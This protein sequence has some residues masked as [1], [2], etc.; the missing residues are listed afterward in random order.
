MADIQLQ[1]INRSIAVVTIEGTAPLIVHAWSQKARTMMLDA[2]QGRKTPKQVKDP[3]A[4]FEATMYRFPDGGHGFPVMAFKSATVKGGGRAFGKNV[5]MTELRQH[6][7]FL[8][9][10]MGVDGMQLTRLTSTEPKMREDLVR[11]GMGTADL[12]YRAEYSEWSADL[13]VEFLPSVIDLGS[14]IAL[15]DAGGSN[16][17]GEWR[18]ERNGAFGTYRVADAS[19]D[20]P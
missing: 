13:R 12:R 3:Q 7:T 17:V 8:P 2:Q 15:I 1:R 4:D 11:V 5:K 18:P 16:G 10:G 20:L 19:E 9:D 6:L 14:I